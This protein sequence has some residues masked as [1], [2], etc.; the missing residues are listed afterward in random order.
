MKK[1]YAAKGMSIY[2]IALVEIERETRN[3]VWINGRR[4]KK[5]S[6]GAGYFDTFDEARS[7]LAKGAR[8]KVYSL[9]RSLSAALETLQQLEGL[10]E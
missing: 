1:Y 7:F 8:R 5:K 4:R 2:P 3:N 10:E 6:A 9:S